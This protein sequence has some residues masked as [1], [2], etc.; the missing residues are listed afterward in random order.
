MAVARARTVAARRSSA[1]E[2][3]SGE[4]AARR[5]EG[6]ARVAAVDHE[7]VEGH[8]RACGRAAEEGSFRFR[9]VVGTSVCWSSASRSRAD[10][11]CRSRPP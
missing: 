3:A 5:R 8:A 11:F 7:E 1:C 6:E 9:F 10:L 4:R 2:R